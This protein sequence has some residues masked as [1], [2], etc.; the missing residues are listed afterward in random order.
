MQTTAVELLLVTAETLNNSCVK[1]VK[2]TLTAFISER[3]L[4]M[5]I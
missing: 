2:D 3:E 1:E 5:I 4:Y